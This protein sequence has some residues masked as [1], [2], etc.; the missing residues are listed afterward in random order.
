[1]LR[2]VLL[3]RVLLRRV[4]L[5]RVLLRRILLREGRARGKE[6]AGGTSGGKDRRHDKI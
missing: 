6:Y 1:L 5:R 4:L 2:R 3:R